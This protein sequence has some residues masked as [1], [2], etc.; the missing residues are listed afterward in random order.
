MKRSI[1]ALILALTASGSSAAQEKGFGT[2][3]DG[4]LEGRVVI[5]SNLD[6]DGP[7]SLRAAV[8][9][10]GPKVV[11][12]EVAGVIRLKSKLVVG[13]PDITIAGQTAPAPGISI[14]NA[15]V[16]V[17][18]HD[19]VI[20][21]LKFRIGD[22][23]GPDPQNRDAIAVDGAKDG[24]RDVRN[25]VIDNCSISWAIDEGVQFYRDGVRDVTIRDS[26]IAANL[27]DSLHPKGR[28]S[29]GLLVGNGADRVSVINN[30]FAHNSFRNP[31][32]SGGSRA[33][34][35]NNLI[36][37]YK[38]R[39]IQFYG[40]GGGRPVEATIVGN[41][42]LVGPDHTKDALVYLPDKVN[43]GTRIHLAD[44]RGTAGDRPEDYLLIA[45]EVLDHVDVVAEPPLWPDGFVAE[46]SG[47]VLEAALSRAGAWPAARDPIDQAFIDD[48][49][50]GTGEII[51]K[52]PS[53]VLDHGVVRRPLDVPDDLQSDPD[54]DG[55]TVL[56]EWLEDFRRLVEAPA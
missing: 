16:V 23:P 6:D 20:E 52:P 5:V 35:A 7:G 25:V 13:E 50:N 38:H 2:Q 42:A 48:I 15:G 51:D 30:I 46:A 31:A 39:A 28:H 8:A 17:K 4:G 36:Y 19:V 11:V 22:G 1:L 21:H 54:G 55:R 37:N 18:T 32:V 14:A 47:T 53:G 56:E 27:S 40:G 10:K 41:V 29:M 33:F 9:E 44:N 43:P 24:G 26:I 45:D 49:R 34:V 12:F 3:T